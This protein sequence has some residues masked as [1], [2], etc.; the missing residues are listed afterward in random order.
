MKEM[1]Q[2]KMD[3]LVEGNIIKQVG[4]SSDINIPA[5]AKKLIYREKQFSPGLWM[6]MRIPVIQGWDDATKHWAYYDNLRWRYHHH[7][8]P[9]ATSETFFAQANW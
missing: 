2:L 8:P 7:D 6:R 3:I 9:S 5:S 4:K 1:K